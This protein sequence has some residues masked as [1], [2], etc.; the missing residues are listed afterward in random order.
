[1]LEFV[2]LLYPREGRTIMLRVFLVIALIA[3]NVTSSSVA[4]AAT[5]E[6]FAIFAL[7][8]STDSSGCVSTDVTVYGAPGSSVSVGITQFDTCNWS[9]V[10]DITA[11]TTKVDRFRVLRNLNTG[12]LQAD[13]PFTDQSSGSLRQVEINLRWTGSG[14]IEQEVEF[15]GSYSKKGEPINRTR[16]SRWAQAKGTVMIGSENITPYASFS[17]SLLRCS[18]DCL[19]N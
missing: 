1:V 19:S 5:K 7:F 12:I 3:G 8:S 14:T 10:K 16:S 17:T 9:H 4:N 13:V 15:S 11:S 6:S 2:D 18:Q